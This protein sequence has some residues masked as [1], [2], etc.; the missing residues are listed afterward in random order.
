V[1]D[2]WSGKQRAGQRSRRIHFQNL[3]KL[4]LRDSFRLFEQADKSYTWWT[5]A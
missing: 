2:P 5:I 3:L 4:G 1:Y